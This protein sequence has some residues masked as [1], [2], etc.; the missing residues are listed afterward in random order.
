MPTAL[1]EEDFSKEEWT[2]LKANG[3]FTGEV[4]TMNDMTKGKPEVKV[5]QIYYPKGKVP[6][7][8]KEMI[9]A[10]YKERYGVDLI[11]PEENFNPT[12]EERR[13]NYEKPVRTIRKKSVR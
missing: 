10:H 13:I 9:I 4:I 6:K 3:Y 12:K 2:K 11:I 7:Q 5:K 1:G 8:A